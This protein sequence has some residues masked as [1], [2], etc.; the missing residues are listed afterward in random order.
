MKKPIHL[1]RLLGYFSCFLISF[2]SFQPDAHPS[3][4]SY[5]DIVQKIYIGYYHRPADPVG[6][7]WW[8]TELDKSG[9]DLAKIIEAFAASAESQT[10]HGS[11][12][13]GTIATVVNGIYNA[14]FGRDAEISG[15]DYYVDGFN[16][17][18]FTA[19]TIMLDVLFGAQNEDL[20]SINNKLIAANLFTRAIDPELDGLDFQ[21]TYAGDG[22]A[23]AGR[24]FLTLYTTSTKLPTQNETVA[25]IWNNIADEGDP[26]ARLLLITVGDPLG[27]SIPPL[28][29]VNAGPTPQGESGNV[30]VTIP[31]QTMGVNAVRTHDLYGPLDMSVMYPDRS[32]DPQLAASYNFTSS[33]IAYDAIISGGFEPY[34]RIGDSYNNVTPPEDL[35]ERINWAEAATYIVGRYL[36]RGSYSY[37]E[38]G[39]EPDFA[40]QF[41][42]PPRT[43]LEFF[44]LYVRTAKAI[45]AAHPLLKVGGPGFTQNVFMKS[46]GKTTLNSFL[47]YV[48]DN[49]A[50]LDF[51]SWHCY[52]N[53]P[54]DYSTGAAYIRQQLDAYGFTS[55]ENH[56]TEWNTDDKNAN[57]LEVRLGGRGAAII[58]GSWIALVKGDISRSL[59]FRGNDTSL[60]FP[61]FY[62]L[63]YADGTYKRNARAFSLWSR[64]TAYSSRLATNATAK[65]ESDLSKLYML[66]GRNGSGQ[67]ALLIANPAAAS[68]TAMITGLELSLKVRV[69]SDASADLQESTQTTSFVTLPPYSAVLISSNGL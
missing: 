35:S 20:A 34:L 45:K 8:A 47:Q 14:L 7:V 31:Y 57:P 18:R 37:V 41:W 25:F 5:Y 19:A 42:P 65:D 10:L 40:E 66:A 46:A 3:P 12:N 50:P 23:S 16:G 68:V 17:G 30:D 28:L 44:D 64:L 1:I 59:F 11:I 9:G 4:S 22:D 63:L 26:L 48:K 56:I 52:S 29:G 2:F 61:T 13:N 69:V 32:K 6:L 54:T 24:N 58:T 55:A 21:A 39:N 33:D 43:L 53:E 60:Q 49:G 27:K 38:I 62:G 36:E 15:L 67:K 51:L